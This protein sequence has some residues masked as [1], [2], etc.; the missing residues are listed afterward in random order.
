[1]QAHAE[2]V[3]DRDMRLEIADVMMRYQSMIQGDTITLGAGS[4]HMEG[5][6]RLDT[7]GR[8]EDWSS[9]GDGTVDPAGYGIGAGHGGYGGGSDL[10][11]YT[12]GKHITVNFV[13]FALGS[14]CYDNGQF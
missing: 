4:V 10:L 13:K 2:I 3:H 11:N 8:G 14:I 7:S 9:V 5:E 1:M 6:A 12:H